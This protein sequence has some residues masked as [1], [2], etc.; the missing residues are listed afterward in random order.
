MLKKFHSSA[1]ELGK[2]IHLQLRELQNMYGCD[3][4]STTMIF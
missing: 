3:T 4:M 2:T 1:I